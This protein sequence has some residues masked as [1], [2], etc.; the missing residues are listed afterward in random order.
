LCDDAV[1]P[2]NEITQR[3]Y[4]IIQIVD[5]EPAG[6]CANQALL[7][8]SRTSLCLNLLSN[9]HGHGRRRTTGRSLSQIKVPVAC[10]DSE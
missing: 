8:Y 6:G 10:G 1:N 5:F 3:L 2:A 9:R 7:Y 4:C